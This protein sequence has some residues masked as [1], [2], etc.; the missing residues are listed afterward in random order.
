M[1]VGGLRG[2]SAVR[3]SVCYL[4]PDSQA[5]RSVQGGGGPAPN[6]PNARQAG[7]QARQRGRER[8]RARQTDRKIDRQRTRFSLAVLKKIDR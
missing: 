3:G 1:A 5:Q 7:K 4:I 2:G 6:F 8:E